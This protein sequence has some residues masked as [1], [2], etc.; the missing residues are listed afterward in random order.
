MSVSSRSVSSEPVG[1]DQ[2]ES[3]VS[4]RRVR[5]DGVNLQ[6]LEAG[7][8]PPLLLLHGHEQSATSWRWVIPVAR[9][10]PSGAG[11]EPARPRRERPGRRRLRPRPGPGPARGRLPRHPRGRVAARGRELRGRCG[12][13]TPGPG[14]PGPG[15]DPDPGR[16]RRSGPRGQP[17]ARPGHPADH[18]RTGHHDQPHA[19]RRRGAHLDVHG[20]A[21]RPAVA[22]TRRVL[23][24]A[25]R[26]GSA[27]GPTRGLHRHGPRP[28]RRER[29]TR[30][31]A[32]PTSHPHDA[33]PGHLG[34]MRLRPARPPRPRP[35]WTACPT[36]GSHCSPTADT[37]PTWSAPTGSPPS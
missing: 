20:H 10:D 30:G 9:P 26:P 17:A 22:G 2:G 37:C 1:E 18:R 21:V 12:R 15:T 25:A 32:R 34:R 31:P 6:Y 33:H 19:G 16:Q 8:G 14:R 23:H 27:T 4:D 11:P 5:V 35:R 7:S 13:A 29:T 28:V 24:R 36:G 3:L